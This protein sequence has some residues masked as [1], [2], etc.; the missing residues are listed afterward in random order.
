MHNNVNLKDEINKIYLKIEEI[1]INMNKKED[2]I[3]NIIEEKDIL[4]K[5]LRN[6]V[7]DQEK[8]LKTLINILI[9]NNIY[10]K[11]IN[12]IYKTNKK[13]VEKIFGDKFVENN[14]NN[15]ELM[16]NNKK[17][18]LIKENEL[19]KG[20]NNIKLIIKNKLTNLEEM[21]KGCK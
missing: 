1:N 13:G 18:E 2:D 17:T 10:K 14:K 6:K 16:I 21:F 4:I 20:E 8:Q 9:E 19:N 7:I 15:I 5:D 12:L 3:K 11:E